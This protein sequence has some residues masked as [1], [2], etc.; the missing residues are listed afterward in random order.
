MTTTTGPGPDP[1]APVAAS[2]VDAARAMAGLGLV[3]AFGHVSCRLDTG[4]GR[5]RTI[6][7]TG[8]VPLATVTTDDLVTVDVDT[9]TLPAGAPPETWAHLA[10]YRQAD[11]V[12]A[13]ARAMP[14]SSFAVG[15]DP[16]TRQ[17]P[18]LHGQAAWL[19]GA[20]NVHDHA[21]L[22][23]DPS[24]AADAAQAFG[25][26]AALVLRGNGA[27]TTGA[28]P[29]EAVT[30]MWLLESAC[31]LALDAPDAAIPLTQAEIESWQ[32][33]AGPLLQRLWGYLR[34]AATTDHHPART[35]PM[36]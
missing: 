21:A 13:V 33:A 35:R 10:V 23:R 22:L 4:S 18:C 34:T 5:R 14:P 32:Q 1:A 9:R 36:A 30:R 20:V 19:G 17:L 31:R 25:A 8:P 28:T 2:L 11:A 27:L 12:A 26:A 24:A 3:S 15:V 29:A 6:L 16:A 7:V